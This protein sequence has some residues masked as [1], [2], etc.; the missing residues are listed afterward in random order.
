MQVVNKLQLT[1]HLSCN[2]ASLYRNNMVC[3]A[4][5]NQNYLRA[6]WL[7][8]CPHEYGTDQTGNKKYWISGFGVCWPILKDIEGIALRK[9]CTIFPPLPL[10]IWYSI[11]QKMVTFS[12]C[13][14]E[15]KRNLISFLKNQS[16]GK[17]IKAII[18]HCYIFRFWTSDLSFNRNSFNFFTEK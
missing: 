17:E 14:L 12:M 2:Y 11:H 10:I 9:T 7:N 13:S 1:S 15:I 8:K 4:K 16:T 6:L 18:F 3:C 5:W